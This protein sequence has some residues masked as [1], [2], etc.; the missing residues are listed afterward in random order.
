[1]KGTVTERTQVNLQSRAGKH[2]VSWFRVDVTFDDKELN[3]S[4]MPKLPPPEVVVYV[5]GKWAGVWE[6]G[7]TMAGK[8]RRLVEMKRWVKR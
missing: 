8:D 5:D 4:L 7:F 3:Y 1:V 6:E 2:I